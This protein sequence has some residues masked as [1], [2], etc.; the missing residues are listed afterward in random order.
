MINILKGE[1]IKLKNSS[2]VGIIILIT[3][4]AVF[5][6]F[7]VSKKLESVDPNNNVLQS[8]YDFSIN[9]YT[10]M[11]LPIIIIIV[12]A[13]IMRFEYL[14]GGIKEILILPLTKKQLFISKLITG[15]FL[16]SISFLTFTLSIIVVSFL[17]VI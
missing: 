15:V 10:L 1:F 4:S 3:L 9:I 5:N 17:K 8:M 13:I 12:F 7:S 2:L 16:V 14:N 11:I 6:G